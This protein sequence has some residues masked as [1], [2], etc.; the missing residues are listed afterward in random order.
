MSPQPILQTQI[1]LSH[2]D[3][4]SGQTTG[5]C[6]S[7][8]RKGSGS[9]PA[10]Y[11]DSLHSQRENIIEESETTSSSEKHERPATEEP[12]EL[13]HGVVA[14]VITDEPDDVSAHPP[15][16][17]PLPYTPPSRATT[18]PFSRSVDPQGGDEHLPPRSRTIAFNEPRRRR[19]DN[20]V[21]STAAIAA[22][23][24]LSPAREPSLRLHRVSARMPG[25]SAMDSG[26]GGFPG[27]VTIATY[28][29]GA[30]SRRLT[31]RQEEPPRPPGVPFTRTATQT[32][33]L[34]FEHHVG[35]NS[36]FKGLTTEQQEELGG[37]EYRVRRAESCDVS[38]A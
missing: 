25:D 1:P 11:T 13:R 36:T 14:N 22:A 16:G 31:S 33:Y 35:R 8:T 24:S 17:N 21:S 30:V 5:Q 29:A 19:P 28:V 4:S 37:I 6:D 38:R 3:F 12:S 34:T 26:Y 2:R 23:E 9:P 15:A 18:T 27:P 7:E 10:T 20:A 32:S